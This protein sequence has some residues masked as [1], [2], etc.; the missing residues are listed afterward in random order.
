MSYIY[1]ASPYSH[2]DPDVREARY[3]E[4]VRVTGWMLSRNMWV[5]SPI[6]HC[7]EVARSASL[8]T[9]FA[10]WQRYNFA[11]IDHAEMF[12]ILTL[13]GWQESRG[14]SGEVAYARSRKLPVLLL[15]P[16]PGGEA[17]ESDV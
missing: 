15:E 2:P 12:Y 4:A 11:M 17:P 6:V 3:R 14:V 16:P 7:H 9:D 5:Y 13:P 8:P 1:L 10:Y